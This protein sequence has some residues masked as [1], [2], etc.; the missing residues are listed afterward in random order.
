MDPA[1]GDYHLGAGSAAINAGTDIGVTEDI[2]GDPRIAPPDIG[3]D[4]VVPVIV[5]S[6]SGPAWFNLGTPVHLYAAHHQ[7]LR[8]ALLTM[9]SSLTQ[10]PVG[11]SFV[12]AS[13]GG[14]EAG[15]E[16]SWPLFDVPPD[17]GVVTRTFAVTA[18]I[19]SPTMITWP[20]FR[21]YPGVAGITSVTSIINHPPSADAGGPQTVRPGTVT[22]DGSGSS[23]PDGDALTYH[24]EQTGG[25]T[26]TLSDDTAES[27]T[28]D[29]PTTGDE[30]TFQ[31]TVTDTFDLSDL[32]APPSPSPTG[33]QRR[34]GPLRRHVRPGT[35]TLDGSGS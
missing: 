23:D 25:T 21:A 9:F 6:K 26:V 20:R 13:H 8:G 5:V 19:P 32:I 4:E 30:L 10:S 31:L 17:G 3:A 27:P 2:D 12:D 1:A 18:T 11:A 29:S 15:G 34:C 35:I 22:L 16:V 7:H 24:W 33:A 28:F 14:S